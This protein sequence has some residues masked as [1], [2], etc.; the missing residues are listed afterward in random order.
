M[1]KTFA[2]IDL[3]DNDL[4]DYREEINREFHE[5]RMSRMLQC[6]DPFYPPQYHEQD[7]KG[8]AGIDEYEEGEA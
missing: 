7:V 4:N 8:W 1:P 6:Y 2:F 5:R 3:S